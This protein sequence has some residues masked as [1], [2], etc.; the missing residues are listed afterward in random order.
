MPITTATALIASSIIAGA[1]GIGTSAIGG[2]MQSK[3][4]KEGQRESRRLHE[5]GL[6]ETKRQF[7]LSYGLKKRELGMTQE[8][9][10]RKSFKDQVSR[11]TGILDK[12]ESLRNLYINRLAGLRG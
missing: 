2:G 6:E 12:N 4:L 3:I 7:D 10:A 9:L 11:L 5:E 1:F 8:A